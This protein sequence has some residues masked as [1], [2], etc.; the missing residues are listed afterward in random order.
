[1]FLSELFYF[2]YSNVYNIMLWEII[3]L[4]VIYV[5]I[6]LFV[7]KCEFIN[8]IEKRICF[9]LLYICYFKKVSFKFI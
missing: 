9:R 8:D 6:Y 4:K 2:E 5:Y 7:L 3:L 1:M